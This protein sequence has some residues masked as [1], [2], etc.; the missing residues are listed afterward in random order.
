MYQ[1]FSQGFL[2]LGVFDTLTYEK[3]PSMETTTPLLVGPPTGPDWE[4]CSFRIV[5]T[6]QN[7]LEPRKRHHNDYLKSLGEIEFGE[8][9]DQERIIIVRDGF[10]HHKNFANG[11]LLID[12]FA[13]SKGSIF[14]I[15]IYDE[16]AVQ[17]FEK[18]PN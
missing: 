17:S 13:N 15:P 18:L 9:E 2:F 3:P 10:V 11:G 6:D 1:A 14:W 5:M 7:N 4:Q 8:I 16:K 12:T